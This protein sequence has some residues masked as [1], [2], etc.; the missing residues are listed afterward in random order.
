MKANEPLTRPA[1]LIRLQCIEQR[2]QI[3]ATHIRNP[4]LFRDDV[5]ALSQDLRLINR[6][7]YAGPIPSGS[8]ER[9][10]AGLQYAS[11]TADKSIRFSKDGT[12]VTIR[13]ATFDIPSL[14]T[15]FVW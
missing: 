1:L 8:R 3:A 4:N 12:S 9:L 13:E 11:I 14:A 7:V 2:A 5:W 10:L 15:R 6:T